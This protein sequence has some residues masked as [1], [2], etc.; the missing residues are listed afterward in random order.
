MGK[1]ARTEEGE[2]EERFKNTPTAAPT[3]LNPHSGDQK[4]HNS[5]L[6]GFQGGQGPR[7]DTEGRINKGL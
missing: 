5:L 2:N 4:Q 7:I 1:M 3:P 6:T